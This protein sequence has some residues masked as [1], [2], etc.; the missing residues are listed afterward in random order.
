MENKRFPAANRRD[1]IRVVTDA[2]IDGYIDARI[3]LRAIVAWHR[4]LGE[5]LS[6]RIAHSRCILRQDRRRVFIPVR[7]A[8]RQRRPNLSPRLRRWRCPLIV[9]RWRNPTCIPDKPCEPGSVPARRLAMA[10]CIYLTFYL[11]GS[12]HA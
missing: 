4:R 12:R 9:L 5:I 6:R 8:G 10:S 3:P 11:N 1:V 7:A 2:G